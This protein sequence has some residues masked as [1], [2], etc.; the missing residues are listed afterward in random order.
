MLI[1]NLCNYLYDY[2]VNIEYLSHTIIGTQACVIIV[3]TPYRLQCRG[4]V[5]ES[6][7][8]YVDKKNCLTAQDALFTCL[9]A[10]TLNFQLV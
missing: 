4:T 1:S 10:Y 9:I 3:D 6:T 5:S 2:V 8:A 7:I